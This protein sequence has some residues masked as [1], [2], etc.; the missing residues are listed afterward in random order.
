MSERDWIFRIDDM[1]NAIAEI[2]SFVS[3]RSYDDFINNKMAFRAAERCFEI[4]GEAAR[5]IP[6]DIKARHNTVP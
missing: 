1:L 6:D 4:L 3:G 2:E 5:K